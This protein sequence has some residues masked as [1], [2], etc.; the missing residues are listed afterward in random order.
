M[1]SFFKDFFKFF[2]LTRPLSWCRL[3]YYISYFFLSSFFE[4]FLK[5]FFLV[6]FLR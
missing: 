5:T 3:L 6:L 4:V 1:S 2:C